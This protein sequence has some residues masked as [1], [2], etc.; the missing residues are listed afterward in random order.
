M[1]TPMQARTSRVPFLSLLAALTLTML[2]ACAGESTGPS[3]AQSRN[4][5]L[6]PTERRNG[7]YVVAE[8]DSTELTP[9]VHVLGGTTLGPLGGLPTEGLPVVGGP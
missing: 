2:T 5:G 8:N 9:L 6:V 1:R 7:G 3:A 4:S